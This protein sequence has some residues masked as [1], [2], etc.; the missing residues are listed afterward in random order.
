M[1]ILL[2]GRDS[3]V[4]KTVYHMLESTKGWQTFLESSWQD[5]DHQIV[6]DDKEKSLFD[7]IMANLADFSDPPLTIIKCLVAQFS[8]L[9]VLVLNS[10]QSQFLIDPL[11]ESGASGYVQIGVSENQLLEAVENVVKGKQC[12]IAENT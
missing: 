8:P 3:V 11:L 6:S 2:I 10:Y 9:P 4:T 7:V 1:D 5:L 12:I